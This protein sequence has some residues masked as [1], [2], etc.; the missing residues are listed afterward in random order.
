MR[1]YKILTYTFA[2]LLSV[3]C[4]GTLFNLGVKVRQVSQRAADAGADSLNVLHGGGRS[5]GREATTAEQRIRGIIG[6]V[7]EQVGKNAAMRDAYVEAF[8][9]LQRALG[10]RSIESDDKSM[11]VLHLLN[12]Q[13]TFYDMQGR[14]ADVA[15]RVDSLSRWC[16]AH[17]TRFI[18]FNRPSKVMK[19]TLPYGLHDVLNCSAD[20]LVAELRR[21]GIETCDLRDDM[22]ASPEEYA[23][24]FYI[25]DNHW[26]LQT[27]L[28]MAGKIAEAVCGDA[29]VYD[30][31]QWRETVCPAPFYGSIALRAGSA[32][33]PG[34]D[35]IRIPVPEGLGADFRTE[36]YSYIQPSAIK[37]G[38][39]F[40]A[41]FDTTFLY[42]EDKYTNRYAGC[43]GGD[44]PL[45]RITNRNGNGVK[46]LLFGDSFSLS[47]GIYLSVALSR[48]DIIDL[49]SYREDDIASLIAG[50]GYDCAACLY[51]GNMDAILF[52]FGKF[53]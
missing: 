15:G 21:R 12:G 46:M 31:L 43:L 2:V 18:Y 32:Y 33:F 3:M 25:T 37:D 36:A 49:R 26:T 19:G 22:P 9:G 40:E 16:E 50:G 51:P 5:A 13:Y 28:L 4:A 39:F 53:F 35:T 38:N 23:R 27:A 52:N 34:A 30:S 6:E 24:M 48:L 41:M 7:E 29:S 8:G 47:A 17:G 11:T 45:I 14:P 42:G 20:S 1:Y 44:H 10:R